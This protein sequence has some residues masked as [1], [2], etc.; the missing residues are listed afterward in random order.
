MTFTSAWTAEIVEL[1]CP[2][3]FTNDGGPTDRAVDALYTLRVAKATI[4]RA[5]TL[6]GEDL[7]ALDR[8]ARYQGVF[9]RCNI[10]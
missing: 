3:R 6:S 4:T 2:R 9:W 1:S 8:K 7:T 5:H 10:G